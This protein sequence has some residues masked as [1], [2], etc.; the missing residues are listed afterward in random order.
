MDGAFPSVYP[1]DE[2]EGL[3]SLTSA[4][5]TPFTKEAKTWRDARHVLDGLS[6]ATIWK[7]CDAMLDQLAYFYPA[8]RDLYEVA[9]YKLSIRAMPKSAADT[10]LCEVVRIG[11]R[12]LRVRAGKI[13]AVFHAEKLVNAALVDFWPRRELAA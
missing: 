11:Q 9:D 4:K 8:A 2:R 5:L 13:D 6:P 3:S 7:R 10:R 1:W 12:A